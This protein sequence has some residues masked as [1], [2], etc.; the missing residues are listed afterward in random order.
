MEGAHI[1]AAED[2]ARRARTRRAAGMPCGNFCFF[3][4]MRRILCARTG[5]GAV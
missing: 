4:K 2:P 1:D 3:D 5:A